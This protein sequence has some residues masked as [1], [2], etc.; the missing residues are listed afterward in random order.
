MSSS[1]YLKDPGVG[2]INFVSKT[3]QVTLPLIT[4][5]TDDSNFE[6]QFVRVRSDNVA[7]FGLGMITNM[8]GNLPPINIGEILSNNSFANIDLI[9]GQTI[10]N[11][12]KRIYMSRADIDTNVINNIRP[13][14]NV[15]RF[16]YSGTLYT[17]TFINFVKVD[18][19][20]NLIAYLNN[21]S[22]YTIS[23]SF[24]TFEINAA[25]GAST[26]Y[27]NNFII[28]T[29]V[30]TSG[31][32]TLFVTY[33]TTSSFFTAGGP[34]WGAITPSGSVSALILNPGFLPAYYWDFKSVLLTKW[35]KSKNWNSLNT[36]NNIFRYYFDKQNGSFINAMN[37]NKESVTQFD[38][39]IVDDQGVLLMNGYTFSGRPFIAVEI[40]GEQ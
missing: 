9:G 12:A 24:S 15:L 1:L 13:G 20:N 23:P 8:Y 28:M 16:T 21:T 35:S 22:N 6:P 30:D 3:Q 19:Q 33:D 40:I 2:A 31:P 25:S 7:T 29:L 26:F 37:W 10:F 36:S 27:N 5:S 11:I 4:D 17:V 32:T 18:T 34:M 38:I 14:N 39:S